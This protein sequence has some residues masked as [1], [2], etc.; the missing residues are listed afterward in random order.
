[1]GSNRRFLNNS[2]DKWWGSTFTSLW[3]RR[4]NGVNYIRIRVIRLTGLS[5]W[6]AWSVGWKCR[7]VVVEED[8]ATLYI[9]CI[10]I[11]INLKRKHFKMKKFKSPF[12]INRYFFHYMS[13]SFF[14]FK[15]DLLYKSGSQKIVSVMSFQIHLSTFQGWRS[16]MWRYQETISGRRHC[17]FLCSSL[18]K[19]LC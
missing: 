9:N 17:Y 10:P 15:H 14:I 18:R 16:N 2:N 1:M 5:H 3:W 6:L 13:A 7:K 11:K 4:S 19:Y 8:H 12:S